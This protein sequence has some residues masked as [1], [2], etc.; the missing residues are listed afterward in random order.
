MT[1]TEVLAALTEGKYDAINRHGDATFR[2]QVTSQK[3]R[4]VWEQATTS[5]GDC[6]GVGNQAVVLHDLPLTFE[7]GEAHL[8]V[9]YREDQIVGLVLKPGAPTGRFGQ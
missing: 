7:R 8:Q 2:S 3:M 9:V 4:D 6:S 1:P 5:W